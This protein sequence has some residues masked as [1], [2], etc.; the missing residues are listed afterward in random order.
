MGWAYHGVTQHR[1]R[2]VFQQHLSPAKHGGL[3]M[4]IYVEVT[5]SI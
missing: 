4:A 2:V 5:L 1:G 3:A